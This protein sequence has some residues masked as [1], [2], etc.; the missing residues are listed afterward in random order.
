MVLQFKLNRDDAVC[1]QD[2]ND[3]ISQLGLLKY[4][5][6]PQ[7]NAEWGHLFCLLQHELK[8]MQF[9]WETYATIG[10]CVR[11]VHKVF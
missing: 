1:P 10:Y 3:N 2:C 8:R 7:K 11:V 5:G 4:L 9:I 6:W